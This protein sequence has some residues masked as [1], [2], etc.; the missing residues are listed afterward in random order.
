MMRRLSAEEYGETF[1]SPMRRLGPD[2]E[3]AFDFWPYFD[4]I[5][6]DDFDGHDCS[7]GKVHWVYAHP[8]GRYEHVLISSENRDIFMVLVLD[9]E[10][11]LVLG[12]HLLDLPRLYGLDQQ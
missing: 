12:H 8:S 1:K 6:A 9:L 4:A 2:A 11:K 5:P 7:A 10:A 3:P